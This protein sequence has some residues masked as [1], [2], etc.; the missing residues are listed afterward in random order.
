M[1]QPSPHPGQQTHRLATVIQMENQRVGASSRRDCV[2]T[3]Q[4]L[5]TRD[6]PGWASLGPP[7]LHFLFIGDFPFFYD[8]RQLGFSEGTL[9][10]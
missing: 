7:V 3:A 4:K 8:T 2:V 1:S 9:Q 5:R 10:S 6:R